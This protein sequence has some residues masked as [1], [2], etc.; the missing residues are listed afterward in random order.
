MKNSLTTTNSAKIIWIYRVECWNG[1]WL[2]S[3]DTTWSERQASNTYKYNYLMLSWWISLQVD[4]ESR[5]FSA[6]TFS[7]SFNLWDT[8]QT[9]PWWIGV[10]W[11]ALLI[12]WVIFFKYKTATRQC[13]FTSYIYLL[14]FWTVTRSQFHIFPVILL[15]YT[16]LNIRTYVCIYDR[17]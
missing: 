11:R 14:W 3:A 5:K 12:P 2:R 15:K 6:R 17:Q 4:V 8:P 10:C 16:I 9:W 7:R 13:A 1:S